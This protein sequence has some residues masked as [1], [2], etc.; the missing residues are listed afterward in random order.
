MRTSRREGANTRA[1]G[2]QTSS[3]RRD[4]RRLEHTDT[5]GRDAHACRGL[6]SRVAHMRSTPPYGGARVE[7][8]FPFR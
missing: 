2:A 3:R 1:S 7:R 5:H 6:E 8:P 4:K